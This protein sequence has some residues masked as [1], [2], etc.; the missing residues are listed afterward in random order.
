MANVQNDM[1]ISTNA[2]KQEVIHLPLPENYSGKGRKFVI[3][4]SDIS[5]YCRPEQENYLLV[6]SED[7]PCDPSIWIEN[8][9][10]ERWKIPSEQ[11]RIQAMRM[12]QRL[13]NL[14]IPNQPKSIV[15][16]YDVTDDWIPIYDKSSLPGFFMACGTSGN[17]YKNAPVAGKIMAN[18]VDGFFNNINHDLNPITLNLSKIN[19]KLNL[20]C[21]SRNREINDQSSFSVLG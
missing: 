4:D 13:T 9:Y 19:F 21:F 6:G 3:S 16:L 1:K 5:L 15:D 8:P 11:S 10:D 12:A 17:Q 2:L 18:L 7:P 14:G 20:S